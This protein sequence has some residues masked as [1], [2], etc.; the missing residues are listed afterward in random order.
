M[1]IE[2]SKSN[3]SATVN[4]IAVSGLPYLPSDGAWR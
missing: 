4:E 1:L 2:F 3:C